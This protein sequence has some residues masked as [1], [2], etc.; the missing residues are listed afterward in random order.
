LGSDLRELKGLEVE[1][2]PHAIRE[3]NRA[4]LSALLD[5][6]LNWEV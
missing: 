5:K 6:R 2:G 1:G 3:E 4:A